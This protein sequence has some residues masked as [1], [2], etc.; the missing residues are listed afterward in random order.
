MIPLDGQ[1][2]AVAFAV[3]ED[4]ERIVLSTDA[5]SVE[6]A[7]ETAALT[8][9]TADGTLLTR[10]PARGGKTLDADRG[11]PVGVRRGHRSREPRATSTACG[12]TP[13]ASGRS[14]DR[15]AYHTKLEFCWAD[16]EALY[17]LGSHEEGMF[18]LRG[19]HQYLYQQNLKVAVPVLVSTRGYGVFVDC[20]SLVTFHDDAFGSY[21]WGDVDEELDYYVMSG[22][23]FD[24]IVAEFRALTGAAPMLPRWAFGYVQSKERY[25]SQAGP[26][27]SGPRVPE[28]WAPAGL[29][30]AGLEVVDGRHVGPEDRSTRRGSR[31]RSA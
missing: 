4:S 26:A 8:Y 24:E 7:R 3:V 6:V 16:G 17:G 22:P 15:I 11:P 9:R 13:R 5:L 23:S 25:E 10:E 12:S 19:Q 2:P 31:I 30:R 1:A 21:L 18:N 20:T 27:R 14:P 29:H 28:A